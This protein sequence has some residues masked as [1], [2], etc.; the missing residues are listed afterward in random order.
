MDDG[1]IFICNT[2]NT[3]IRRIRP[4]KAVAQ[5]QIIELQG[6]KEWDVFC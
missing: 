2:S 6:V 3:S 1:W 4:Y 5:V